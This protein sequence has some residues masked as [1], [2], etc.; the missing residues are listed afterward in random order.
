MQISSPIHNSQ[1]VKTP[2]NV[3]QLMNG[4]INVLEPYKGVLETR[5]NEVLIHT[6]A[7]ISL[8]NIVLSERSAS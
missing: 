2:P 3:R 5:R 1:K 6:T 7:W 8:E 4:C